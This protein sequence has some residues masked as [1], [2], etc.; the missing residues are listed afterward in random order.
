MA[1]GATR[2]LQ[3]LGRGSPLGTAL[4][5]SPQPSL[6]DLKGQMQ[7]PQSLV[8][9]A[10]REWQEWQGPGWRGVAGNVSPTPCQ[11]GIR[12]VPVTV[13]AAAYAQI[14][15]SKHKGPFVEVTV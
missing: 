13:L 1:P 3:G 6:E 14:M 11:E 2:A 4:A 9:R 15:R 8:F 5:P 7:I 10:P 12:G